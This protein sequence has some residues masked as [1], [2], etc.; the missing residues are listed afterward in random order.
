[1][2]RRKQIKGS[3]PIT[4]Y[5]LGSSDAQQIDL[6]RETLYTRMQNR[7]A[8]L[9]IKIPVFLVNEA[10]MDAVAPPALQRG[11]NKDAVQRRL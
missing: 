5:N 2:A 10:Q 11:L 6:T 1:M 8:E 3:L 4:F 9:A 7:L